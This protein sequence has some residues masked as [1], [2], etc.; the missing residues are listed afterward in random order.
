MWSQSS[1]SVLVSSL[2]FSQPNDEGRGI[3]LKDLNRFNLTFPRRDL[4]DCIT[5]S[6]C[7]FRVVTFPQM[8]IKI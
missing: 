1:Y 3:L 5:E 2:M 7:K 6:D 8:A 4:S